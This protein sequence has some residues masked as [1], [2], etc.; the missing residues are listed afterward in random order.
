MSETNKNYAIITDQVD[1]DLRTACAKIKEEGY[2]NIELHNVFGK[3][4]EECSEEETNE[5]KAIVE[6]YGLNVVNLATTVFF[7]CPLYDHY[8]VSLF[9]P[10]FHAF[11]GN[12]EEHLEKLRNACR[13]AN[14]LDCETI[15]IFPFRFPDNEEVTVVGTDK[16]ME[17]IIENFKKAAVIAEENNVTLVV[18]NCPYSHCPKGEMT[19]KLI[20]AVNSA[21]M[22][23]LWD[24]ANSY[25]AEAHRV[26]EVYKSLDLFQEYELIKGEVRHLHVK[27]YAY[28][29]T[30]EKPF[31]HTALFDGDIDYPSLLKTMADTYPYYCS[32]EPEVDEE[33]TMKS[34]RELKD[35]YNKL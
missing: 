21:H 20:K 10:M 6:E 1:Q 2:T 30:L 18:E 16:D 8:R 19:Y 4:I 13:I 28:D 9:N 22:K 34:M 32:L 12:V 31:A 27:N 17:R 3:S 7:L 23:L 15:R 24:P 5:I 33:G 25:R 14:A 29:E 35:F 26:P 11:K